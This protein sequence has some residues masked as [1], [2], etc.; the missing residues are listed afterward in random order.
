LVHAEGPS[1][2]NAGRNRAPKGGR[3][4]AK[5]KF[6]VPTRSG[7]GPS[8]RLSNIRVGDA[9]M[10]A[11]KAWAASKYIMGFINTEVKVNDVSDTGT[12]VT[13]A[14]TVVNLSN[15]AQG[16]DISQRTGDSI[17]LRHFRLG[18]Y[19]RA[20]ATKLTNL[21]RILVI[22]DNEQDGVDPTPA[23]ITSL[24]GTT[25][26]PI[27]PFNY[28]M[29]QPANDRTHRF[30]ILYDHIAHPVV[31]SE[32]EI[33]PVIFE[34]TYSNGDKHI[35]FDDTAAADASNREGALFLYMISEDATLG[36]TVTYSARVMYCDN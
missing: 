15:I 13:N 16:T 3:N 2:R 36:P 7:G 8:G 12:V 19:V 28:F 21:C 1:R 34:K 20:N 23:Q 27:G 11:Q 32:A 4:N 22:R 24:T 35:L 9:M 33:E 29:A 25:I 30:E 6:R 5:G 10:V 18:F 31:Q 26:A 17:L 14:G